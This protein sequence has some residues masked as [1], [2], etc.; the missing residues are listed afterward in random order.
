MRL[1][2][3][4]PLAAT[5]VIAGLTAGAAPAAA[6]SDCVKGRTWTTPLL[7]KQGGLESIVVDPQGRIVYTDQARG[8]MILDDYGVSPRK[9]AHVKDPGGLALD[10]TGH[11]LVG[12][13]NGIVNGALGNLVPGSRLLRVN[14]ETGAK[15]VYATGLQMGNGVVRHPDG[16]V[17]AS[18]DIGVLGIDRIAPGGGKA[19]TH[20]SPVLS[21]NG[22]ALSP[23][24]RTLYANQTF[25]PAQI[26]AIPLATPK[27]PYV[28]FR[29]GLLDIAAGLDGMAIDAQGRLL[30]T[31]W[32]SGQVWR[33]QNGQACV[34]ARG[35]DRPAA[36]AVSYGPGPFGGGK[37]FV[38][39]HGGTLAQVP[40]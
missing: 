38:V 20:W 36:V 37:I 25:V 14:L 31:A 7:I 29:A 17:F 32:L 23:D 18:N 28:A 1:R 27:K 12:E 33:I 26:A 2:R 39:T 21:A 13:G 30:V 16:T 34:L 24:G 19:Q 11:V 3:L 8:L 5:I 22:L 15:S 40:A 6:A 10:G 35:L 9:L 4:A